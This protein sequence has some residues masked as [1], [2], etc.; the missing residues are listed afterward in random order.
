MRGIISHKTFSIKACTKGKL[1]GLKTG[2]LRTENEAK[3]LSHYNPLIFL[4]NQSGGKAGISLEGWSMPIVL[5][6]Q[7]RLPPIFGPEKM[8]PFSQYSAQVIRP[9]MNVL[10]LHVY[11]K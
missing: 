1:P 10:S 9:V 7:T 4:L 6:P 2:S 3:G 5:W 11:V 8:P